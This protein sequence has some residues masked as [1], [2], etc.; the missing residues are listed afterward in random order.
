MSSSTLVSL[1]LATIL[2]MA[3][4][5]QG[6]GASAPVPELVVIVSAHSAISTLRPDQVTAIFLGQ[7]PQLPDGALLTAVDQPVGTASRDVFYEKLAAKSPALLKA[8][9]SKLLFT[10]RGQPPR[11]VG[12]NAA[13]K[14]LVAETPGVIGY[15]DRNALDATVRPVL[16]VR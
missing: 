4:V 16:T 7:L 11:E 8:Y 15:I 10:G 5:L 3:T 13:V 6:A 12:G 2:L 14:K 9:W 1:R